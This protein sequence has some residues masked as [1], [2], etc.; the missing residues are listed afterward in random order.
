[1]LASSAEQARS[2]RGQPGVNLHRP[3]GVGKR[4]GPVQVHAP[5]AAASAADRAAH[6][7]VRPDVPARFHLQR[8]C[9]Y[10][11][12]AAAAPSSSPLNP[13]AST[14]SA[15]ST[16]ATAAASIAGTTIAAAA[17]IAATDQG[18]T[19]VHF[20]AQSDP[21]QTQNTPHTPPNTP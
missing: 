18:L 16:A 11:H 17:A 8:P 7:A 21:F 15:A 6:P 13:A 9:E 12:R 10:E 19:L 4:R 5:A 1:M 2:D 14:P 20:P 3:T